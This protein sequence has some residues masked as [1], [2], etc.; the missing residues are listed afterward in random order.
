M[1]DMAEH[2]KWSGQPPGKNVS[3]SVNYLRFSESG[4]GYFWALRGLRNRLDNA[5]KCLS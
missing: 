2:E 3:G 4:T 5:R 1:T